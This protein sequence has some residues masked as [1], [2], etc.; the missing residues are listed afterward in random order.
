MFSQELQF[1]KRY[2]PLIQQAFDLNIIH[3]DYFN[4]ASRVYRH[5]NMIYHMHGIKD[6][7]AFSICLAYFRSYPVVVLTTYEDDKYDKVEHIKYY[8]DQG[9]LVNLFIKLTID[10][11][12][13]Q[14][15]MTL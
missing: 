3:S 5:A 11:S 13:V 14:P 4:S 6:E 1:T 8:Y 15:I 2:V 10:I 9:M 7:K 12:D